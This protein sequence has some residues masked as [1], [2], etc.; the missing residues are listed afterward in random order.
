MSK[1]KVGD[2]A[3][4]QCFGPTRDRIRVEGEFCTL[5]EY[6]GDTEVAGG[7]VRKAWIVQVH[8]SR[9]DRVMVAEAALQ[10][11]GRLNTVVE[12]ADCPWQPIEYLRYP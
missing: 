4:I 11:P 8:S 3:I 5:R 2:I 1:W 7:E 10:V 12:W 6:L 9:M